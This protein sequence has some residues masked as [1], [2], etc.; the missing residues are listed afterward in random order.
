MPTKSPK[1]PKLSALR[2]PKLFGTLAPRKHDATETDWGG[3]VHG[4]F[5]EKMG[6][7]WRYGW[8]LDAGGGYDSRETAI[9]GL[10]RSLDRVGKRLLALGWRPTKK[11]GC[12]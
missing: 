8:G 10:E 9:V 12:P 2:G 6:Q 4:A 5:V 7:R 11:L 1:R 3:S